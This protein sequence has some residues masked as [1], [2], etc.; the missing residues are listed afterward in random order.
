MNLDGELR[1]AQVVEM[2]VAKEKLRFFYPKGLKF[3]LE[4]PVQETVLAR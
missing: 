3:A 4:N 1:T 2:S